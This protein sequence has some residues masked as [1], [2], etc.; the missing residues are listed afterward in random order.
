MASLAELEKLTREYSDVRNVVVKRMQALEDEIAACKRKHLA[1]IKR[2]VAATIEKHSLLEVAV[3]ASL[4]IFVRPRTVIF[5][6]VK[7]GLQKRKG[8]L[9]WE[10]KE[11]VIRLIKKYFPKQ[12]DI[13]IQITE[14]PVES[15]LKYLS[16][17]KLKKLG[18]SITDTGD[19][20]IIKAADAEI[21]KLVN[22][23]L[24]DND[25]EEL[26]AA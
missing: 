25:I 6:G 26:E 18:I 4:E 21:D 10:S 24:R 19:A 1:G 11:Q 9:K 8:K 2:A 20:V 17:I 15:S 13:L 14:K 22:A 23:Y 3:Q 16:D 5:H 7:I 12:Q